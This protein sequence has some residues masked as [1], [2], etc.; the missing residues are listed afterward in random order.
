MK[1]VID[2]LIAYIIV[3]HY[4]TR[5]SA[6]VYEETAQLE[7]RYMI[8]TKR[9]Y[10]RFRLPPHQQIAAE[11]GRSLNFGALDVKGSVVSQNFQPRLANYTPLF[12]HPAIRDR[13]AGYHVFRI[14]RS[15]SIRAIASLFSAYEYA[16]SS[17]LSRLP[18]MCLRLKEAYKWRLALEN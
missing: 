1:G 8:K 3:L 16:G 11:K 5:P 18:S 6:R 4:R 17:A 13:H 12:G 9:G 7:R 10:W 15:N 14:Y 2:F